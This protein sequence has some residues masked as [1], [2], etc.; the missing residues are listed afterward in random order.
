MVKENKKKVLEEKLAA[1]QAIKEAQ[2]AA[3]REKISVSEEDATKVEVLVEKKSA[4]GKSDKSET[5]PKKSSSS[6]KK[7]RK[8]RQN[9]SKGSSSSS[10]AHKPKPTS[11]K[12]GEEGEN[13]E[14][15]S[16]IETELDLTLSQQNFEEE[17]DGFFSRVSTGP[18][19]IIGSTPSM[20]VVMIP[21][22]GFDSRDLDAKKKAADRA[23]RHAAKKKA[24]AL[25]VQKKVKEKVPIEP[26][27]SGGSSGDKR[28]SSKEA[29]HIKDTF[30][31]NVASVVVAHL[32][33]YRK[34]EHIKTNDDFKH[35]ARKVSFREFI[36]NWHVFYNHSSL[37]YG[38]IPIF[39][40]H[41]LF[42]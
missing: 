18:S 35:L 41:I 22:L 5:V 25:A 17:N 19:R 24:A 37:T 15:S 42:F 13:I 7:K 38:L 33:A 8:E 27:T 12:K 3:T 6:M 21:G 16:P 36:N 26:S 14:S 31:S 10:G 40:S 2:H 29:S 30:R 34:N 28:V 32:N 1:R 23:A 9:P 39:R 20:D 4:G 11:V